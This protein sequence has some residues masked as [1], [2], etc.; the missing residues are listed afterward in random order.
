MG[1]LIKD[2]VN[3]GLDH[4]VK[5]SKITNELTEELHIQVSNKF[6]R[7][8]VNVND[9]DEIWAADLI[10]MQGFSKQNKQIK[11][12]LTVID[13]FSK[14]VWIIPLK[15]K[16]GR[17]VANAFSR[18]LKERRPD[19]MWVDKGREF[20]NNDVQKL[21][22]FYSREN[23]EK[24][25]VIERFNR[26]I[27]EKIYKYFTANSTRKYF[28]VLDTFVDQYN[29]TVHSSIKIT[30]VEASLMK[31]ENKVWRHLYPEFGGKTLTP[32]CSIGHVKI[33]NKKKILW[34]GFYT[35]LDWRGV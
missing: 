1:K 3:F 17:E 19:K 11:Y 23:D 22:E 9:I 10:D 4:P 2:E 16:T 7:R 15:Q 29:N 5:K 35:S 20:Y 13:V 31:N 26:T 33:T 24:S 27:K 34:E 28:D 14:C 18:I 6:E 21:V 25:C 30:P 32:K 12:L 8:R